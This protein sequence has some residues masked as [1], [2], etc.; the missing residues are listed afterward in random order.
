V[1]SDADLGIFDTIECGSNRL[2]LLSAHVN[3]SCRLGADPRRGT[4]TPDGAV[5][6]ARGVYVMDGSV[7]PTALGVNP[8]ETIMAVA[9][10]LA[11]RLADRH[12]A[13]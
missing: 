1:R 11:E 2:T 10:V 7:L 4:C 6:G 12:P 5:R 9:T 8:Q 3:G 13:G